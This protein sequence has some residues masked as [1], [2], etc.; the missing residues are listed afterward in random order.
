M[1]NSFILFN[2]LVAIV[3]LDN[4]PVMGSSPESIV[5]PYAGLT[6]PAMGNQ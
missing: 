2:Q 3:R 1:H 4:M 5:P 6:N